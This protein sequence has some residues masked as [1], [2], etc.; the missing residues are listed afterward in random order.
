VLGGAKRKNQ[1]A[2]FAHRAHRRPTEHS[3]ARSFQRTTEHVARSPTLVIPV[4]FSPV[5]TVVARHPAH[6]LGLYRGFQ[7]RQ[8]HGN[9]SASRRTAENSNSTIQVS[10]SP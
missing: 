10:G 6:R 3:K 7:T 4:R 1:S 9:R 5:H 8:I 2:D